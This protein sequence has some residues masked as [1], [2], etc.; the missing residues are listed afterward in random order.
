MAKKIVEK[1]IKG[2]VR[3]SIN[4]NVI[5]SFLNV[6]MSMAFWIFKIYNFLVV[7]TCSFS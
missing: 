6:V 5:F 4:K 2:C 1:S 7:N 3:M